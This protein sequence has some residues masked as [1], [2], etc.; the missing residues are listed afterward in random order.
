M[1]AGLLIRSNSSYNGKGE[2]DFRTLDSSNFASAK[3]KPVQ[4]SIPRD[5]TRRFVW[6]AI[7]DQN[8]VDD[9]L[10]R[11]HLLFDDEG[12]E[13]MRVPINERRFGSVPGNEVTWYPAGESGGQQPDLMIGNTFNGIR[14]PCFTFIIRATTAKIV[15]DEI[16]ING[17]QRCLFGLQVLSQCE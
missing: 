16:R 11:G 7:H 2:A 1:G 6:L 5:M 3:T 15:I 8:G 4:M 9:Y 17:S 13:M 10:I 14:V 12:T